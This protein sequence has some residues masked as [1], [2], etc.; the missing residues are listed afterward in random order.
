MV[1]SITGIDNPFV[2]L[3]S[4][5]PSESLL[6]HGR[7][8]HTQQLL[9]LLA[10]HRFVGVMGASGSGK[11]SLVKAGLLPAL[12]RGY[13]RRASSRWKTAVMRPGA[14]PL[15]RLAE[16]LCDPNGLAIPQ[17]PAGIAGRLEK[18]SAAL[19]TLVR[20]QFE[21][22]RE[23]ENLLLVVDQFEEIF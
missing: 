8:Q 20:E 18:N 22:N 16:A 1:A 23:P 7:K 13:L 11:S 3:R 10:S 12:H 17:P 5:E 21:R 14:S 9:R 6:F 15:A 19:V 2:G 4:F